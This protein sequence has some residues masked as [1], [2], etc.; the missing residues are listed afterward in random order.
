MFVNSSEP[1]VYCLGWL[2]REYGSYMYCEQGS[3]WSYTLEWVNEFHVEDRP[4]QKLG[5]INAFH[6]NHHGQLL[7]L[8]LHV[9]RGCGSK[10]G[11]QTGVMKNNVFFHVVVKKWE[12]NEPLELGTYFP[13]S[14][15]FLWRHKVSSRVGDLSQFLI[16]QVL[17]HVLTCDLFQR[18][19][20]NPGNESLLAPCDS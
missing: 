1:F 2:G 14:K 18:I 9:H 7:F 10:R 17:Q 8:P 12:V 20:L 4:T 13:C 5:L 15:C 19:V 11:C 16:L 6:H 3:F